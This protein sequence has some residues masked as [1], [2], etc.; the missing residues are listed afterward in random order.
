MALNAERKYAMALNAKTKVGNGF[1]RQNEDVALN[2]GMDD[3][4]ALNADLRNYGGS[5]RQMKKWL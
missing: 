2:A 3:A 4:M 5:E 1:E